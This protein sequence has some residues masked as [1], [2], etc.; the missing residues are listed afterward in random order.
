MASW[1]KVDQFED[2]PL[3]A[4]ASVN[5]APVASNMGAAG[6]GKLF[7][8]ATPDNLITGIT[9]G[10]FNIGNAEQSA[11]QV[12]STDGSTILST[13]G[14]GHAG[15]NLR[16]VGSGGRANRVQVE[17]LVCLTSNA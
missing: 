15:W 14:A 8:N 11:Q 13:A 3:W 2:A 7:N 17:T 16:T 6:S 9:R 1:G 10:L 12:T 4:L 5:L